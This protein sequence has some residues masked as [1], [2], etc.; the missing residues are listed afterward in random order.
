MAHSSVHTGGMRYNE[1]SV[2]KESVHNSESGSSNYSEQQRLQLSLVVACAAFR[3]AGVSGSCSSSN[4]G[5]SVFK[6]LVVAVALYT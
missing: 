4:S 2:L 1:Y 3:R 5:G 6:L